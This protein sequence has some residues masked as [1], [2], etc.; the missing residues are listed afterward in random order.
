MSE[1]YPG[2]RGRR[3]SGHGYRGGQARRTAQ[4]RQ[5][6]FAGQL[7]GLCAVG[8][9]IGWSAIPRLQAAWAFASK[10]PEEIARIEA[11]A[12]YRNCDAARAAGAA[13]IHRGE[14]GYREQ[15]DGDLD[16]IA[17]EPYRGMR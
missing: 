10:S 6:K 2:N 9:V 12:Y 16:G 3:P 8:A 13:P 4:R 17:C 7:I 15:M 1:R 5:G 11:S 14:P